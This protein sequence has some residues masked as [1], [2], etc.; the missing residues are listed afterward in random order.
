MEVRLDGY[1]RC[2]YEVVYL[3]PE[4]EVLIHLPLS[5]SDSPQ[6]YG[7]AAPLRA[8]PPQALFLPPSSAVQ[9]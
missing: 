6:E 8:G 9:L 1:H 5:P 4:G 3:S 2:L 7:P